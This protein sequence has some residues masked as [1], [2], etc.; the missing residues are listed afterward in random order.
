FQKLPAFDLKMLQEAVL[1][2]N[3]KPQA[4]QADVARTQWELERAVVQPIPNVNL[5]G[6]YQ[7]EINYPP[8]NQGLFQV[9]MAV[10]LFDRNQGNIRSARAEIASSRANLRTI[11]LDLANQAAQAVATYRTSQRLVE[12]YEQYIIPKAR[13]TV[14]LTQR[15]YAQG[16]VT[17]L[18]LL[19]AQRILT[20]T[21]LAYVEAQADRWTGAVTIAD[22]LQLE[23]FP[24]PADAPRVS[25]RR[26][27]SRRSV[28]PLPSPSPPHHCR[29]R[30]ASLGRGDL[31]RQRGLGR[32]AGQRV[33]DRQLDTA[34]AGRCRL[35]DADDVAGE[36]VAPAARAGLGDRLEVPGVD[37][38][39]GI[40]DQPQ[41]RVD[42]GGVPGRRLTGGQVVD[43]DVD[44]HLLAG[45]EAIGSVAVDVAPGAD[46][47]RE[48][49]RADG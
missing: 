38:A 22:L 1:R 49:G 40:V 27:L 12:W 47:R 33:G 35:G 34:T 14:Q 17:F 2:S 32:R 44:D 46:G 39:V 4:A 25:L 23:A 24:P 15:L 19:Q 28:F 10:P 9:Q 45:T 21:E 37:R 13:E 18:S 6:G 5:M 26:P 36:V 31:Q 11:E 29:S 42:A 16:E 48:A 7:R 41:R 3:A 43:L 20:E 8:S 30:E